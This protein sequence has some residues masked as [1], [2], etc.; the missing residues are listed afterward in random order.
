[1]SFELLAL[2]LLAFLL[3]Y[4]LHSTVLLG[5]AWLA[6]R[7]LSVEASGLR[8]GIWRVALFGGFLTAGVQTG[9]GLE[10][11]LGR[12][13]LQ[14]ETTMRTAALETHDDHGTGVEGTS[15]A[16]AHTDEAAH[17]ERAVLEAELAHL[18]GELERARP[19]RESR[20]HRVALRDESDNQF[21]LALPGL[22]RFGAGDAGRAPRRVEPRSE[23]SGPGSTLAA[24]ETPGFGALSGSIA[25]VAPTT[26]A[27]PV[28]WSRWIAAGW[29]TFAG[30]VVLGLFACRGRLRRTLSGKQE[31]TDGPLAA[32]LERLHAGSGLGT[33]PRL[34]VAP[35][36]IVPLCTGL[37]R[38]AICIP[39]RALVDLT[40]AEQEAMLAH[41]LGHLV[42]RDP[43][44]NCLTWVAQNIFF[45]QPLNRVARR[46]LL[47]SSELLADEWAAGATG[48]RL[49]LASCLTRIATW[50]VGEPQV[51]LA[52][53][54]TRGTRAGRSALG[55]RVERLL[56]EEAES[57]QARRRWLAPLA[58]V[59]LASLALGV[60]GFAA[61]GQTAPEPNFPLHDT[62]PDFELPPSLVEPT[63]VDA[64][65]E[66]A[67]EPV[68]APWQLDAA[69]DPVLVAE[70]N[71]L[72]QEVD[73]LKSELRA[74]RESLAGR[75]L[76]PSVL[77]TVSELER[78]ARELAD[79]RGR[80][81]SVVWEAAAPGI[82][83]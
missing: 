64:E 12:W 52:P 49:S 7:R 42:R 69:I 73:A 1:M 21:T 68:A 79:R 40:A 54:M 6:T 41:E 23:S 18:T 34:F 36:L 50:L 78:R 46:E 81:N 3:T 27:T 66:S 71:Q 57:Q 74:L 35:R 38:P 47:A 14:H 31:L 2:G 10:P 24:R 51:L 9:L 11:P 45:F 59:S 20:D 25:R 61:V 63:F 70:L 39:P 13:V 48:Q 33:A 29:S 8:E 19:E 15:A 76:D 53:Q 62:F 43:A 77:A 44:W 80:V 60:P 28:E 67:P 4:W 75:D 32:M 55:V 56:D 17:E 83:P 22:L 37:A 26:L 65:P 58:C 82:R 30:L 72:D 16:P 5:V